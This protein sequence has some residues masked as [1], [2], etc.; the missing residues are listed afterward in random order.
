M[1]GKGKIDGYGQPYIFISWCPMNSSLISLYLKPFKFRLHFKFLTQITKSKAIQPKNSNQSY[2][3]PKFE[4]EK[5][6]T[7][8]KRKTLLIMGIWQKN[9]K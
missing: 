1:D 8:T 5:E 4:K 3:I 6:K 7:K 2:S 9:L